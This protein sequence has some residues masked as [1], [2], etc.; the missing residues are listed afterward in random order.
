MWGAL[1]A[2]DHM[3]ALRW[4]QTQNDWCKWSFWSGFGFNVVEMGLVSQQQS[5]FANDDDDDGEKFAGSTNFS[6]KMWSL[7]WCRCWS[8]ARFRWPVW[9]IAEDPTFSPPFR[10]IFAQLWRLRRS[11]NRSDSALFRSGGRLP[12]RYP[13]PAIERDE[14]W[15]SWHYYHCSSSRDV[16]VR[17]NNQ[18]VRR[19]LSVES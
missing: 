1:E 19:Q 8:W 2:P 11:M 13:Y 12:R 10:Q 4:D 3:M 5:N 17:C 18:V 6:L 16:V 9:W 7:H 14:N 15:L